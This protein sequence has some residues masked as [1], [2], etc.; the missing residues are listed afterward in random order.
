MV[1]AS[2][3]M[4]RLLSEIRFSRSTLQLVTTSGWSMAIWGRKENEEPTRGG[5]KGRETI[6]EQKETDRGGQR[7]RGQKGAEEYNVPR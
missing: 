5:E 2:V 4:L 7:K 1:I 6:Q 3:A